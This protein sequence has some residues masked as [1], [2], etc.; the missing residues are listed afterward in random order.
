[1]CTAAGLLAG[2]AITC[3]NAA[4]ISGAR[5]TFPYPIYAKWADAYKKQTGITVNYQSVGSGE[6]LKQIMN[7]EVAFGA[8]DMPLKRADLEAHGLVQ[9]PAVVGGVVAVVNVD[10]IKPGDLTLDGP[11]L[12][13]IFLGDRKSVV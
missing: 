9:F 1:M 2:A 4:E 6:G 11:T 3:V 5:A 7:R 12:A 13:R 10:G 8:S